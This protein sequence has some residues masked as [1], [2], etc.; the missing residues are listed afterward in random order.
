MNVDIDKLVTTLTAIFTIVIIS[1]KSIQ[2]VMNDK[3]RK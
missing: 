2:G 3:L 1:S